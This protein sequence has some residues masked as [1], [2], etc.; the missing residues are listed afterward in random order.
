MISIVLILCLYRRQ[1]STASEPLLLPP[2]A[3]QQR[4]SAVAVTSG[5]ALLSG[6]NVGRICVALIEGR[7]IKLRV[8]VQ[9]LLVMVDS[10]STHTFRS[11]TDHLRY[12]QSKGKS[13]SEKW[14][15]C[16]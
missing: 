2:L 12:K 15:W 6:D 9:T 8:K 10:H 1:S 16:S 11:S 7:V 13:E 14:N 5:G 4:S 3:L